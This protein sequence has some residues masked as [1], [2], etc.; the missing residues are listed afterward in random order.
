MRI[1]VPSMGNRGLEEEVSPHFGR[2]PFF[3]IYDTTTEKV[4]EIVQNTSQHMGGI[5]YPPELMRAHRVAVMLCSGL[6]PR[7]VQMF[8]QLGIQVYVGAM[9]TVENTINA[10][11]RGN[12]QEATDE[13][14]CK[15]HRH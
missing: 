9:G 12:L 6:G 5:G 13:T 11:K 1:S 4:V 2:A 14:V 10:W 8:E 7:A 15:E 3:T